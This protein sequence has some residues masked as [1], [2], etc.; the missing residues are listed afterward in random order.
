MT[1]REVRDAVRFYTSSAA[2]L[3]CLRPEAIRI[4]LDGN[5]AGVVTRDEA[6]QAAETLATRLLKAA[7]RK[8][9]RNATAITKTSTAIN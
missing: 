3:R 5:P 2:Y 6:A 1:P 9:T 4:N 7:N 8:D